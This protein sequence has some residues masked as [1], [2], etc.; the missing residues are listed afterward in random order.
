M[1]NQRLL[2]PGQIAAFADALVDSDPHFM[3]SRFAKF[4]RLLG[5]VEL[6]CVRRDAYCDAYSEFASPMSSRWILMRYGT[7]DYKN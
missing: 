3:E 7:G 1:E 4:T 6:P 2:T 5:S